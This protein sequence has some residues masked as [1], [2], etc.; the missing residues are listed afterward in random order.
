MNYIILLPYIY[1][2]IC[3]VIL[4]LLCNNK[5]LDI[6][7][8]RLIYGLFTFF[9]LIYMCYF[10]IDENLFEWNHILHFFNILSIKI[11]K[12]LENLIHIK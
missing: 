1:T 12:I 3:L 11:K 8:F 6:N 9:V 7:L 4:Y 2:Y 10:I 5:I